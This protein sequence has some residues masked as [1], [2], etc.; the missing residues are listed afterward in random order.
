M[1]VPAAE[2]ARGDVYQFHLDLLPN[3]MSFRRDLR[4][5]LLDAN[6]TFVDRS[7]ALELLSRKAPGDM[8][9]A[10]IRAGV[11]LV[12]TF[13][14]GSERVLNALRGHSDPALLDALID[15]AY[16]HTMPSVRAQALSM[17]IDEYESE[18]AARSAIESLAAG[19]R[20][21]LLKQVGERAFSGDAQWNAYVLSTVKD[22]SLRPSE[23]FAPLAYLMQTKQKDDVRKLLDEDFIAALKDVL[24]GVVGGKD[25]SAA[26]SAFEVMALIPDSST[27]AA[28]DLMLAVWEGAR[29]VPYRAIAI[30]PLLMHRNDP[31]VHSKLEAIASGD[32]DPQMRARAIEAL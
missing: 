20:T 18:P 8:D 11:D 16:K 5:T 21:Q 23:R 22:A 19:D 1:C 30:D 10:V 7:N 17:L 31:R 28:I 26:M 27:P 3:D 6:E 32:P 2:L 24:P 13:P 12:N 14:R 29:A 4:A 25:E 15:M 9:S